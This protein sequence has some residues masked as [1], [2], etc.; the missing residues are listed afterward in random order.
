MSFRS[1]TLNASPAL[2]TG[3]WTQAL[4]TV[5]AFCSSRKSLAITFPVVRESVERLLKR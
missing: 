4:N 1:V 5:L 2:L 3:G